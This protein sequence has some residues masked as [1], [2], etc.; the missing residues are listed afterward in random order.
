MF[1]RCSPNRL[2][3]TALLMLTSPLTSML[4]RAWSAPPSTIAGPA[5]RVGHTTSDTASPLWLRTPHLWRIDDGLPQN[6]VKCEAQAPNGY[7]WVATQEGVGRFDGARFTNYTTD[8]TP[9]LASNNVHELLFDSV[10]ALW[11]LAGGGLTRYH[12]GTFTKLIT[13][14]PGMDS[15]Q[16]LWLSRGGAVMIACEHSIRQWRYGQLEKIADLT[17]TALRNTDPFVPPVQDVAG[18]VWLQDR[19][20]NEVR[21]LRGT[22]KV[23]QQT[24]KMS[25]VNNRGLCVDSKGSVWVA[26]DSGIYQSVG[27]KL[28]LVVPQKALGN[29]Q[30]WRLVG[31]RD[32]DVWAHASSAVYRIHN[33]QVR[34]MG[35]QDGIRD[36]VTFLA[37]DNTGA[38]WAQDVDV[39][40]LH[41]WDGHKFQQCLTPEPMC[42]AWKCPI[43]QD[44]EGGIW[45]GTYGGICCLRN[46]ACRTFSKPDGLTS[47]NV[48]SVCVDAAGRVWA[49]TDFGDLYSFQDGS[50]ESVNDTTLARKSITA[51]AADA[52]G[53]LWTVASGALYNVVHGHARLMASAIGLTNQEY[54]QS[55]AIDG[56]NTLWIGTPAD[57]VQAHRS[58]N[59]KFDVH[60]YTARDGAPTDFLPVTYAAPSGDVWIGANKSLT[61]IHQGKLKRYDTSDGL[62]SVPIISVYQ[63]HEGTVWIGS[64]G[65]GLYRLKDGKI[66]RIGVDNGLF[67]NSIQGIAEDGRGSLVIASSRGLFLTPLDTLNRFADGHYRR[68]ECHAISLAD[69]AVGGVCS[70]GNQPVLAVDRDGAVWAAA[71]HGAMRYKAPSTETAVA[72][73]YVEQA[74]LNGRSFDPSEFAVVPPG[75]GALHFR[76]TS[77]DFARMGEASFKYKLEGFDKQWASSGQRRDVDYTNLPPGN[78]RFCVTEMDLRGNPVGRIARMSFQIKPHWY[79]TVWFKIW[80]ILAFVAVGFALGYA[81]MRSLA[82]HN[83][84]LEA[85][86]STRTAELVEANTQ[87]LHA[88]DELSEQNE[89]LQSLQ[90][91]LEAQNDELQNAKRILE[92]QNEDLETAHEQLAQQNEELNNLATTDGLTS[93]ANRRAFMNRLDVEWKSSTRYD[94]P[95]SV[96]LL[97]VDHFKQFNDTFGHQAGD[98]VLVEVGRALAGCARD[99]DMPARYGGEEFIVILPHTD[100]GGAYAIAE[101]IREAVAAIDGLPRTVTVS[102]GVAALEASTVDPEALIARADRALYDSKHNGRNRV[103]MAS[104]DVDVVVVVDKAA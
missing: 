93:L 28:V 51:I 87:I 42:W 9:G 31:G 16:H 62:P 88:R 20:N 6:V 80:A 75:N 37:S 23:F 15:V 98:A 12:D 7:I 102:V 97:D 2:A 74:V 65:E 41:M 45:L 49:G 4:P 29:V 63:D 61:R 8:N 24:G 66:A 11:I 79:E 67:A 43:F 78:Y 21:L 104:T 83:R 89:A 76:F 38:V 57:V 50:F 32:G 53:S 18:A 72:P 99:T 64:W 84:Q 19:S 35:P 58:A 85:K 71:Q 90:S 14:E 13:V 30:V 86:V 92:V 73:T 34:R 91:E 26:V 55:L 68:I 52:D 54:V 44:R 103:T 27:D 95:L 70:Q 10:G 60:R 59:G 47:E 22:T 81:R 56:S 39:H 48:R 25:H 46:T 1:Y 5:E 40:R 36:D 94:L 96:V 100:P 82:A 33:R 3:L 69:G 101:R 17:D 77:V